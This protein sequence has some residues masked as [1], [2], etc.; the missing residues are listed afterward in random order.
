[1]NKIISLTGA[2]LIMITILYPAEVQAVKRTELSNG[3]V[4]LT[5]PVTTNSIVSVIV[6]LKMGSLYETDEKAGL[7]TLMQDTILKGT[8]T[9]T[10][11]QIALELESLGTRISSSS[12]REYGTLSF[13]S[14]A[15]SLDRSLDILYDILLNPTFPDDAVD[16]Q[17]KLQI[18]NILMR[19]DQA[20]YQAIEL[21]VEAHF[22]SHPFH[23]PRMGYPETVQTLSRNDL[24]DLYKKIYVPD[25]MVICVVGNFDESRFIAGI[26]EKLGALPKS[27]KPS[28]IPGE[29]IRHTAPV[30]KTETRETA[31]SWFAL[32]WESPKMD[33]PDYYA[34][35][36][37]DSITGGSMNSRLFVAIR[38]KRGL[39]YQVS[40]FVNA[41]MEAGIFV[42]YIG[43]KPSTYE[44]AKKVLLEEVWRMGRENVTAEELKNA[45]SYLKGMNIM[46]MESN[47][48][49]ASQYALNEI[50]GVGY[51][52]G[53]RYN[54]AIEKI[55]VSDV[56]NVGKKYLGDNYS[57]GAVLAK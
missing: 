53:D 46:G 39:A 38:E 31:A 24:L 51:D 54:E 18:R 44:E 21:M 9:R 36:V 5:K 56:R 49:Q 4:I 19:R 42:A 13:Q 32:G 40:S 43:T 14:T 45:K 35:E 50:L 25:N 27:V 11:E 16:L 41:R 6:A 22:G 20:I 48:G 55:T 10:S 30:E 8:T 26:T 23:K 47:T 1:M 34:M 12:D 15:E 29:L 2:V 28:K 17:K 3:L 57:L 7:C 37:L 52:F 33:A